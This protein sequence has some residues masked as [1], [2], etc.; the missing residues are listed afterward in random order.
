MPILSIA[1]IPDPVLKA[2][3]APIHEITPEIRELAAAMTDTMHHSPHCVGIAAPQVKKPVRLVVID[4]SLSPKP[5]PN[6]GLLLLINPVITRKEGKRSGREGCLSVPDFTGNVNRAEKVTVQ[7]LCLEGSPVSINA[8]G[9]EAVLLQ[10]EIDH[11]DGLLFLDRVSSLK[12]D[13]F[14]R[15][16]PPA[17]S[18]TKEGEMLSANHRGTSLNIRGGDGCL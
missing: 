5:Q 15:K 8:E 12:T 10:H 14:R 1:T 2:V 3:C 4:A 13:V 16:L 18:L 11:L 7:A 17:P 6:H 9:F